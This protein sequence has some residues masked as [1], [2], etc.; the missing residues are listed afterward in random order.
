MGLAAACAA[1][2]SPGQRPGGGGMPPGPPGPPPPEAVQACSGAKDGTACSFQHDGHDITG[3]CRT[4][5]R[6]EP[7]ACAPDRPPPMPPPRE[8]VE[9]CSGQQAGATCSFA[10][11]SQQLSGVC[12]P[13]PG[14]RGEKIAC[15]PAGEPPPGPPGPPPEAVDACAN[16]QEGGACS[17]SMGGG[18][19]VSGTCR[20]GPPG[21]P[22]ACFP[23]SGR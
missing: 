11:G 16:V 17:F 10:I 22:A 12:R 5:P 19:A 20:S 9:A 13:G 23:S 2:A 21:L 8:A 18:G 7:A 4:G 15:A 3:T 14:G 1:L 6:G